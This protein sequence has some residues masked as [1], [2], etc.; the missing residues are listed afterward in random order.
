MACRGCMQ[1]LRRFRA[2]WDVRCLKPRHLHTWSSDIMYGEEWGAKHIE[3]QP[4]AQAEATVA[5]AHLR[6]TVSSSEMVA[7]KCQVSLTPWAKLHGGRWSREGR[8]RG[9]R[10]RQ[11]V[12]VRWTSPVPFLSGNIVQITPRCFTHSLLIWIAIIHYF[13]IALYTLDMPPSLDR[14]YINRHRNIL[15]INA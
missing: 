1:E 8:G 4:P 15:H 14:D 5:P 6:I 2:S 10:W 3:H 11:S 9:R 7:A 13:Q 12:R